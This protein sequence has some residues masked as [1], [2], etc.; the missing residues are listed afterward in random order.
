[1]SDD[2]LFAIEE[3]KQRALADHA[4]I[5]GTV[6]YPEWVIGYKDD[7][8]HDIK[9]SGKVGVRIVSTQ[10]SDLTRIC[11]THLDPF[12]DPEIVNDPENF[13]HGYSSLWTWGNPTES[14]RC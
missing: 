11:D 9:V 14:S 6:I 7:V 10:Q 3:A 1:M 13:L 5:V 4:A 2:P 8:S 12:W